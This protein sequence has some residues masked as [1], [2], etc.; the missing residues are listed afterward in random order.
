MNLAASNSTGAAQFSR[1]CASDER[2]SLGE[3]SAGGNFDLIYTTTVDAFLAQHSI[4]RVD[5][6]KVC[7]ITDD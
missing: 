5:V 6:L 1:Q 3:S 4:E 2:C 7:F